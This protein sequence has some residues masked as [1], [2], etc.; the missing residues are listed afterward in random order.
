MNLPTR[1]SLY[2][3]LFIGN[4]ALAVFTTILFIRFGKDAFTLTWCLGVLLTLGWGN[5]G[6]GLLD[7]SFAARI[8][9]ARVA[10]GLRIAV[11]LLM[12]S[13]MGFALICIVPWSRERIIELAGLSVEWTVLFVL[14]G[15]V[16]A[17]AQ[18]LNTYTLR[19]G[20]HAG[21]LMWQIVGRLAEIGVVLLAC[22]LRQPSL[23]I[24]A[25]LAYPI[26]QLMIFFRE[27]KVYETLPVVTQSSRDSGRAAW[28]VSVVG[29]IFEIVLPTIW[30][31]VAGDAVFVA[32]RSIA[33]ALSNSVLLPRYWYVIVSPDKKSQ[34]N[35]LL[36][37]V[38]VIASLLIAAMFQIVTDAVSHDL[39]LLSLGP[40]VLNSAF[41]PFVSRWRQQCLLRGHVLPP[42]FAAIAGCL[43]E[44]ALLLLLRYIFSVP[45]GLLILAH[46]G[47]SLSVPVLH[48]AMKRREK[49]AFA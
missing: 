8:W 30:L 39:L 36:P 13:V 28:I 32:Y 21:A 4:Q 46:A 42:A 35:I 47:L 17:F 41:M 1:E 6:Y 40:L 16:R 27:R 9:S 25:W 19:Q 37:V 5:A 22:Y 29:R 2:L 38:V 33:A 12:L 20:H 15:F 3:L 26:S 7:P 49:S 23:L 14:I 24:A 31:R 44:I 48:L 43:G 18:V 11:R 34:S 10:E 45:T